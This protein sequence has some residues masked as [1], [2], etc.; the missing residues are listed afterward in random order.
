M[1]ND[2]EM[3]DLLFEEEEKQSVLPEQESLENCESLSDRW[4]SWV[5]I[6]N[7]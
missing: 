4:S 3:E 6:V 2:L 5:N 1:D 7:R